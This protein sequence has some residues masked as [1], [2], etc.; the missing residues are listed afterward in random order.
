MTSFVCPALENIGLINAASWIDM[1]NDKKPDLVTAADFMPV[2]I[3]KNDGTKLTDVTEQSGLKNLA[4]LW[5]SFVVTDIDKD[6]DMNIVAGNLGLNN[7]FHIN[8]KQPAMLIAKDFDGNGVLEPVFCYYIKDNNGEYHLS[9]GISRDELSGQMPSFKKRFEQ[10]SSY[11]KANMDGIFTKEMMEGAMVLTCHEVRNGYFENDGKGKFAFHPFPLVAQV[12][13]VNA[14]ACTDVDG[15]GITDIIIAGNEYQANVMTGRYDA[16]YGM[17]LKGD[18]K[19][20]FNSV[21]PVNSGLIIDG[22]VKDL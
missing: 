19:G 22:D 17:F 21:T 7:P 10:N 13:P 14:I 6:G 1:D 8:E 15:D 5:R 9:S 4:G 3:L 16:S 12:A 2:C 11:A 18:G 20:D